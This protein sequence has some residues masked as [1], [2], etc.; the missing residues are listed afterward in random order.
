MA[1]CNHMNLLNYHVSFMHGK[2]L[3][4][5]LPYLEAGSLENV[6]TWRKN[7]LDQKGIKD[8]ILIATILKQVC[9]ALQYFH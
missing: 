6:L 1:Q 5:I 4:L 8:E 7:N 2:E 9:E 3:W